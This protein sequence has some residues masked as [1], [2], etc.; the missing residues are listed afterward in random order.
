M[1]E[2][3]LRSIVREHGVNWTVTSKNRLIQASLYSYNSPTF[4]H[5]MYL[6]DLFDHLPHVPDRDA[7]ATQQ[8]AFEDLLED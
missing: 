1:V 7:I 4:S 8:S 5:V 3:G 2:M 6:G